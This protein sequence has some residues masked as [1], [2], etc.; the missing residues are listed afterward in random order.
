MSAPV[1]L[2][3]D[4]VRDGDETDVDCGGSCQPCAA[5]KQCG[6]AE[7]CYSQACD[8]GTC[9]APQTGACRREDQA[10]WARP[11]QKIRRTESTRRA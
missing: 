1:N 11:S 9:R 3:R 8:A 10:H 6:R 7:D 5:A 2:C 4:R